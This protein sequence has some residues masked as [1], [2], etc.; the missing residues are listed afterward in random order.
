MVSRATYA[1]IMLKRS[2]FAYIEVA[3]FYQQFL[4]AKLAVLYQYYCLSEV[5][6]QQPL[7]SEPIPD[8]LKLSKTLLT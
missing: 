4:T 6:A 7:S 8:L 1:S 2:A 5:V 3:P